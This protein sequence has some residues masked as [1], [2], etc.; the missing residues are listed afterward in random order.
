MVPSYSTMLRSQDC[1]QWCR[2]RLHLQ[3]I[4]LLTGFNTVVVQV[5]LSRYK[6][7][8]I[9]K[10]ASDECCTKLLMDIIGDL[11]PA[12]GPAMPCD[13]VQGNEYGVEYDLNFKFSPRQYVAEQ[14]ARAESRV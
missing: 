1:S 2:F 4:K 5:N 9:G 6:L 3:S 14:L 7:I 10:M 8:R 13:P 11:E 12:L